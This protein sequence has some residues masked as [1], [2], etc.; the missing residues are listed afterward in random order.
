MDVIT[1]PERRKLAALAFAQLLAPQGSKASVCLA[2]PVFPALVGAVVEVL[3][4]VCRSENGNEIDVLVMSAPPSSASAF[5]DEDEDSKPEQQQQQQ[6]RHPQSP[7]SANTSTAEEPEM[8]TEHD[9]RK[10]AVM[11][12]DPVHKVMGRGDLF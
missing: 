8:E 3:H 1:Q 6:Q 7:S 5:N 2:A 11:L 4:D 12:S 9:K 10:R